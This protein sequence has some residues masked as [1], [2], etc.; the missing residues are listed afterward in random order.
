[1]K[2][3]NFNSF[4]ALTLF[5]V[6]TNLHPMDPGLSG[7]LALDG[8]DIA[9]FIDNGDLDGIKGKCKQSGFNVNAISPVG[10]DYPLNLALKT[11]NKPIVELLMSLGATLQ[12]SSYALFA[13]LNKDVENKGVEKK[14]DQEKEKREQEARKQEISWAI[15][16][17]RIREEIRRVYGM[18]GDLK[19]IE[20]NVSGLRAKIERIEES[21]K[22][23]KQ[24]RE[25]KNT[26]NSSVKE[27]NIVPNNKMMENAQQFGQEVENKQLVESKKLVENDKW[28]KIN[29]TRVNIPVNSDILLV[30]SARENII[31]NNTVTWNLKNLWMN[32]WK[33]PSKLTI[34]V[35]IDSGNLVLPGVP[36]ECINIISNNP[37]YK[38]QLDWLIAKDKEMR[39]ENAHL[40]QRYKNEKWV[41]VN[42]V[43]VNISPE[44]DILIEGWENDVIV[45]GIRVK[46]NGNPSIEMRLDNGSF[47]MNRLNIDLNK[48]KIIAPDQ[49]F[50]EE[51]IGRLRQGR[52]IITGK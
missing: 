38:E 19:D 52:V 6:A 51:S 49:D 44:K 10:R 36:F 7:K 30:F 24:F 22:R 20:R 48:F 4:V 16:K 17:E 29:G 28:V 11:K 33:N 50:R 34:D 1:M 26:S 14:L 2:K 43:Q 37:R 42:D 8:V 23:A 35:R 5:C 41:K 9:H 47:S 39:A 25:S 13:E 31:I 12:D 45:N 40:C 3:F 21:E 18:K 32:L 15:E 46:T 27:E